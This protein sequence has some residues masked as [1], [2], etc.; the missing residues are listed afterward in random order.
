MRGVPLEEDLSVYA[1]AWLEY[2]ARPSKRTKA[3]AVLALRLVIERARVPFTTKARAQFVRDY[4]KRIQTDKN[5]AWA[6]AEWPKP[7]I[8]QTWP[9]Y[10]DTGLL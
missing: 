8:T 6:L 9:A 1:R 7:T 3:V 4:V 2:K 10:V 5:L